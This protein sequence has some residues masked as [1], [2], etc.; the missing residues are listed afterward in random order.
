MQVCK[1]DTLLAFP[2]SHSRQFAHTFVM[3]SLSAAPPPDFQQS[4]GPLYL[5]IYICGWGCPPTHPLLLMIQCVMKTSLFVLLLGDFRNGY[6][7][8]SRRN[9]RLFSS[10]PNWDPHPLTRRRE[11]VPPLW[12]RGQGH[13]LGGDIDIDIL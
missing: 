7:P 11:C 1:R 9:T 4:W 2:K 3:C 10:R 12:F 5:G 8:Q 13:S 6:T